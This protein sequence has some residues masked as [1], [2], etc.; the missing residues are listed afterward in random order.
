MTNNFD[1]YITGNTINIQPHT[2]GT[3][4]FKARLKNDCGWS[5]WAIYQY[6]VIDC[7]NPYNYTYY[8]NPASSEITIENNSYDKSKGSFS[9][10]SKNSKGSIVIYDFN[11]SVLQ[12]EEYNLNS[13]SFN[14][15]VSKL[16]PGNYFMKI[17]AAREEETYQI[18]IRR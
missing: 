14:L 4:A 8:P 9:S 10:S 11:G 18:V 1:Y 6:S 5:V 16:K 13:K 3:I 17:G 2:I 7:N 15:D 12:T